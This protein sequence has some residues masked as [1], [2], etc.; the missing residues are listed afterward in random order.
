MIVAWWCLVVAFPPMPS[1]LQLSKPIAQRHLWRCRQWTHTGSDQDMTMTPLRHHRHL[2]FRWRIWKLFQAL[3][4][5]DSMSKSLLA[6][7][8]MEM[9]CK[10]A[11]LSPT[12]IYIYIIYMI[13]LGNDRNDVEESEISCKIFG[14]HNPK[15]WRVTT[16]KLLLWHPSLAGPNGGFSQTC[17]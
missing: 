12:I 7:V 4:I 9:I 17:L 16:Q 3:V 5:S 1:H 11:H 6:F 8:Q 10:A 15:S 14:I 13:R 2:F